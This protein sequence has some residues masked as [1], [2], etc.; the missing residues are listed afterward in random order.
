MSA[1]FSKNISLKQKKAGFGSPL[2]VLLVL[3]VSLFAGQLAAIFILQGLLAAFGYPGGTR[4]FSD[5]PVFAQ[6]VFVALSQALVFGLVYLF[7]RRR[8]LG[9]AAIGLG[10]K[11]AWSDLWVSLLAFG[12]FYAVLIGLTLILRAFIPA[13]DVDQAQNVGFENLSTSADRLLAFA[14]LV[15]LAPLGEELVWRGY[16]YSGLRSKLK[17]LPALL[18]ASLVFGAL[19]LEFGGDGPLNWMAG[20]A[21]FWLSAVMIYTREKTGALYS[22]IAIHA[23]NNAVAFTVVFL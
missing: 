7:M 3:A 17:F 5:V 1:D 23:L 19:H 2:K 6:F 22:P 21:T 10:R 12:A 14:S 8:R 16:F 11:P 4:D 15:V 9:L 18:S 13:L 20:T